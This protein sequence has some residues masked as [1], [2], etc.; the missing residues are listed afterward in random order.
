MNRFYQNYKT[1]AEYQAW[2]S[3]ITVR[4]FYNANGCPVT[5]K[6]PF[7]KIPKREQSESII[8]RVG[9]LTT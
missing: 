7:P 2:H 8:R 1:H 4:S 5:A 3:F 9:E 6:A